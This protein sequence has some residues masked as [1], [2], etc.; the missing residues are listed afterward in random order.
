MTAPPEL[1]TAAERL[2]A[3]ANPARLR[4]ALRLL[5]GECAVGAIEAE[6]GMRQPALSQQLAVLREAGLIASRRDARAVIYALSEPDGAAL[7]R[8]LAAGLGLAGSSAPAP[9][10][11][12]RRPAS[13]LMGAAFAS[14]GRPA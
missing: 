8:G 1:D 4:I 6:L 11:P 10:V 3:L 7:V 9:A 5:D 12:I 14:V 13:A 2:R